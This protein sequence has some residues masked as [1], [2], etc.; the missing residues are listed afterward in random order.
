MQ[1]CALRREKRNNRTYLISSNNQ[2]T[3]V[4]SIV[5]MSAT[6]ST[7]SVVGPGSDT[8]CNAAVPFRLKAVTRDSG[9]DL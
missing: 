4:N 3:V 8:G 7:V 1:L 9:K 2:S 5:P 6:F